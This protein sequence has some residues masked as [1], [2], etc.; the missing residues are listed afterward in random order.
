[1]SQPSSLQAA[2]WLGAHALGLYAVVSV[3]LLAVTLLARRWL[4]RAAPLSCGMRLALGGALAGLGSLVF[5]WL[6]VE[7]PAGRAL[8]AWDVAF[9]NALASVV[10]PGV[11]L[12]AALITRLGD[13]TTLVLLGVAVGLVLLLRRHVG[14]MLAW[15]VTLA[16]N[17]VLN[18]AWKHF[19][20]RVRPLHAADGASA[21]GFSFPSGHSSGAVVTYGMLAYLGL[22]LLP[23]RWHR[24]VLL[25]AVLLAFSVGA[26]RIIL[27]VHFP[28]DVAAGFA[29][30][31]VWLVICITGLELGDVLQRRASKRKAALIR[32]GRA[33]TAR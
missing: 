24:P 32:S 2:A 5:A 4:Q 8:S 26:S 18:A 27:G 7:L 22:R 33:P 20:A 29:W 11:V 30:G 6:A 31:T 13:P 1:M 14:L 21:L 25:A 16:G 19:F 12:A 17:G 10:P 9:A 23:P 3:A 15:A 28:S